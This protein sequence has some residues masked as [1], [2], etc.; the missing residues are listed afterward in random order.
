MIQWDLSKGDLRGFPG[1]RCSLDWAHRFA[2]T[3]EVVLQLGGSYFWKKGE[4]ERAEAWYLGAL[5]LRP[6]YT[7]A[8]YNL[9][10]MY[11]D[12][13]RYDKAREHVDRLPRRFPVAGPAQET[14]RGWLPCWYGRSAATVESARPV[15][16]GLRGMSFS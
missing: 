12:M 15:F 9:G 6:D 13:K 10:L 3:D 1:A 5:A 2:P 7:E 4:N 8:H 16:R 11:V 14:G